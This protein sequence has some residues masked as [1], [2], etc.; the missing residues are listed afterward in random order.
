MAIMVALSIHGDLVR[1]TCELHHPGVADKED[2]VDTTRTTDEDDTPVVT[3]HWIERLCASAWV[4][5]L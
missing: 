1:R 4:R 2:T 3:P 5:V